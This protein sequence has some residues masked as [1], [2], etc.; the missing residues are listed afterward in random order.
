[1][2]AINQLL[3]MMPENGASDM[4]LSV[5]ERPKFKLHGEITE[6]DDWPQFTYESL[7]EMLLEI[8][9]D[10][11]REKYAENWDLDLAHE[12]E[13]VARF[14]CNYYMQR[15][16]YAAVFRIIPS[17]IMTLDQLNLPGVLTRFCELRS[18]LVLVTGPTGSGKTTTLAAMINHINENESRRIVTIEDPV[19][20][21]HPNKR[22]LISHREVGTHTGSFAAALR[23][24]TRQDCDVVLVGEM[25]DLETIGL[26]LSAAAMGTLVFGTLHTNSAAKTI[27]RIIDVFP[28][29]Q[30]PQARTVLAES[31]RG[32]VAQQLLKKKGGGRVA[33]N[34]ILVGSLAVST[35]I[36][37]GR[38]ER[39][40]S[41]IQSGRRDGM[42]LMDDALAELVD[43]D[44]ISGFDA[45][46]RAVEK[47][48]FE[49]YNIA[50]EKAAG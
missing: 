23:A 47:K 28:T 48:R 3:E 35:I 42:R 24:I 46:M 25:R 16:G 15:T 1:M 20:F 38:I 17:E 36:R 10:E 21:V 39:I 26:A 2:P 50:E 37:E 22:S 13:G 19:E 43:N 18:G 11:Q 45:Y 30:Q 9:S 29:D 40:I 27:D 5:G 6:V 31:L 34:E 44:V 4:F 49:E 14:R 41:V 33:V 8:L 7:G 32:I 12:I